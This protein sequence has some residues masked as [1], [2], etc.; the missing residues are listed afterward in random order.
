VHNP[1]DD[2]LQNLQYAEATARGHVFARGDAIVLRGARWRVLDV[3]R[4]PSCAVLDLAALDPADGAARA[5]FLTPFDRPRP[6]ESGGRPR[7]VSRTRSRLALAALARGGA[8]HATATTRIDILPY[9]LEPALTLAKGRASRILLADEVGLGKTIQ[10]G[11]AMRVLLAERRAE[12]VLILTPASLR[13]QWAA[14]LRDRFQI[15]AAIVDADALKRATRML[16]RTVNP[17]RTWPVA[18]VSLDFAKRSDVGPALSE[19][20]W[21]MLIVDEAHGVAQVSDRRSAVERLAARARYVLLLTATPHNGDDRAYSQLTQVGALG[22]RDDL[23]VIRRTKRDAGMREDR[24]VHLVAVRL[25]D[26]ERRMHRALTLYTR[27]VLASANRRRD[28]DAVIAM[29]V[30]AKRAASGAASLRHSIERRLELLSAREPVV[31][32]QMAL[33]LDSPTDGDIDPLDEVPDAILGR[34]GLEDTNEEER[35]LERIRSL[36]AD[37]A[38]NDTKLRVVK[39]LLRRVREPLVIFT[40][41]RDTLVTLAAAL[42]DSGP[43]ILHGGIDAR[44]RAQIT[45]AFRRGD[46]PLLL[47]TDVAAEGLNLQA[48][49]RTIVNLELPWTPARLEQRIGRVD[50]IGQTRRVH[51]F[52]LCARE[53]AEADVLARL[54]RRVLAMQR[55]LGALPT[56]I[57]AIS[58]RAI[59]E[60]AVSTRASTTV[61][62]EKTLLAPAFTVVDA[63]PIKMSP[64]ALDEAMSLMRWRE[65]W[66]RAT[67]HQLADPDEVVASVSRTRPWI[68]IEHPRSAFPPG[69]VALFRVRVGLGTTRAF[70]DRIV[71]VWVPQIPCPRA[72]GV[73]RVIRD[74]TGLLQSRAQREAE[75]V[76]HDVQREN[77]GW[78]ERFKARA[79]AMGL[80]TPRV[81]AAGPQLFRRWNLREPTTA[82]TNAEPASGAAPDVEL[83][84]VLMRMR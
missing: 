3:C 37:A 44:V 81:E 27:R 56:P 84:L 48:A 47:T 53:T 62:V 67:Q 75:R 64:D 45:E 49:C 54:L 38:P 9:Q 23:L 26:A 51:A 76:A 65:L 79:P 12:R 68:A 36:A 35:W 71:P 10:A 61:R 25:T 60:A 5:T 24:R 16:P 72:I 21:D 15:D 50:R 18:I 46:R 59:L 28:A 82:R 19:A 31:G 52:N 34:R 58:D 55:A 29:I 13:E 57:G 20:R 77:E 39:T 78:S 1:D 40:E 69:L 2:A 7:I 33:P 66:H 43:L 30:L 42:A 22:D 70:A 11:L 63:R 14:E 17:W 83:L 32:V 41:Y 74:L 73:R 8:L 4:Y 80:P 6:I